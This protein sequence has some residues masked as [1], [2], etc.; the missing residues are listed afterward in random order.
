MKPHAWLLWCCAAALAAQDAQPVPEPAMQTAIVAAGC[1]WG[2]EDAFAHTAGVKDAVS[3]YIGGHVDQPTYHQVCGDDTGH[4]E[5]VRITFDPAV[6]S[7]AQLLDVFWN[8]HDPTQVDAQGPDH[9]TQYRSAIFV[10]DAAQRAAAE[11]SKAAAQPYFK[12]PIA[13]QIVDAG[14]FWPAEA[15]HQDYMAKNGGTCHTRRRGLQVVTAKIA[16]SDEQWKARLTADQYR[17]LRHGGTEA[18]F[19]EPYKALKDIKTGLFTCAGCGLELF[20]AQSQFTSG[21][22]WPSFA[23]PLPGRVVE[24]TDESHGMVRTEV[25]CY[26]CDGHLGHVFPDGP[27]PGGRRY[28]INGQALLPPGAAAAAAHAAKP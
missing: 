5:A 27:A 19:C 20:D 6:V 24:V 21:T 11:A 2:V 16:L 15:Y 17:I 4:A 10:V 9:G 18:P 26:R 13:T 23:A 7:F 8:I 14:T 3:G 22:G 25:R 1:F 28:C 12:Q